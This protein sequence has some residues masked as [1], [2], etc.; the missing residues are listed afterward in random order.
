MS[1]APIGEPAWRRSP[2]EPIPTPATT[3]TD[4]PAGAGGAGAAVLDAVTSVVL[5][6]DDSVRLAVAAFLAGGHVLVEDSPGVGK[7]L[8]GKALARALGGSFGRIQATADL[9]PSDITGVSV[10]DPDER[11]WVFR[12]GPVFHNVVLVDELNRA[13]PRAQS[14][15]LEAMAEGH[16]TVDG[17]THPLPCPFLVIATQN[18][19]GDHGTFPLVAGQRDR[20]AARVHLGIPPPDIERALLRGDGGPR[21]LDGQS[22]VVSPA[23]WRRAQDA[24]D[25]VHVSDAVVDYLVDLATTARAHPAGDP[26]L[27][28]RASLMLQRVAQAAAA[29]AGRDHVLPDDVQAVAPAVLGHRFTPDL[30]GGPARAEAARAAERVAAVLASVTVPP[31]TS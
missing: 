22:A 18:P 6:H 23:V 2:L 11:T 7:T 31:I 28:P 14:A 8:L 26:E 27:S 10:F 24:V 15:L 21:R 5:G 1:N 30:L 19:G 16:V 25:G 29:L 17:A 9:L 12:P 4:D 13:T 3:I 20:F